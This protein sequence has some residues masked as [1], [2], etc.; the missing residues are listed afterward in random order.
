M[1][2]LFNTTAFLLVSLTASAQWSEEAKLVPGDL[3]SGDSFGG[4]VAV[5]GDTA[6]VGVPLHDGVATDAGAAYVYARSGTTW[7]QQAKLRAL[8][9]QAGDKFGYAVAVDGDTALISAPYHAGPKGAVYVFERSGTTWSEQAKL[10]LATSDPGKLGLQ[11]AL[12]GDTAAIGAYQADMYGEYVYMYVRSGSTWSLQDVVGGGGFHDF[13]ACDLDLDG[14]WL[15]VGE[16]LHDGVFE[17]N[18]GAAYV[19][20]RV[21]SAWQYRTELLG[22]VYQNFRFGSHV[23]ISGDTI[24]VGAG[25]DLWKTYVFVRSGSTWSVQHIFDNP[26]YGLD[27]DG[28]VALIGDDSWSSSSLYIARVMWRSGTTWTHRHTLSTYGQSGSSAIDGGTVV[29]GNPLDDDAGVDAGAA[30]AISF[31]PGTGFCFGDPGSGTP[32]PCSN[33]NDGSVPGSGCDNGVFASGAKLA[34]RGIASV[35]HDSVALY[36][37]RVEPNNSGLYF[38]ASTAVN[39]GD[40]ITF[41]DGLRCAGG[42]LQRLQVRFSDA[43]GYSATTVAI[44]AKTGISAGETKRY[45]CWYRNQ[46]TPAC[47]LGVNEFNLSNGY[48]LVWGP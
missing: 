40:G 20:E 26:V 24:L 5:S 36:T 30:H 10:M 7:V 45:Q 3:V 19:Y 11:L 25:P 47:G 15:V 1:N 28:D 46:S 16:M 38:Q 9:G 23:A 29:I 17:D 21:G 48:E 8:D 44:A 13:F 12:D 43:S 37:E 6:V 14:D 39:G 4:V 34:A 41:G 42:Q 32:C 2:A 35:T 22:P 18:V 31:E 27:I 33:D